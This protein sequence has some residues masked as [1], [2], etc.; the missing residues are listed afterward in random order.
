MGI[1]SDNIE[2]HF[3]K[4]L[5]GFSNLKSDKYLDYEEKMKEELENLKDNFGL[6]L[7]QLMTSPTTKVEDEMEGQYLIQLVEI[8][9]NLSKNNTQDEDS[10]QS[11]IKIR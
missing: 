2:R 3:F 8:S 9:K 10:L 1:L 6:K 7:D 4:C 11:L 5:N